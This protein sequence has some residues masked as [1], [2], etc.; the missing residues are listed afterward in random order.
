MGIKFNSKFQQFS[1]EHKHCLLSNNKIF[2]F[3]NVSKVL[4]IVT[5]KSSKKMYF[6]TARKRFVRKKNEYKLDKQTNWNMKL[7]AIIQKKSKFKKIE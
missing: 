6:T 3:K 7:D 2:N 5:K 4:E 1:R